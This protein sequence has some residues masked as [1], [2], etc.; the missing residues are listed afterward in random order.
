MHALNEKGGVENLI[1]AASDITCQLVR[2]TGQPNHAL[3][4]QNVA[5]VGMFYAGYLQVLRT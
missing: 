2:V 3:L 5:L 1:E 4:L